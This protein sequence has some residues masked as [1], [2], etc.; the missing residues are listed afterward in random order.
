MKVTIEIP[1]DEIKDRL[2]DVIAQQYYRDYST[3]RRIVERVTAQCV[4]SIIYK[5]K[6]RIVDRIVSQA[7]RHTK[8]LAVKK[9]LAQM[10]DDDEV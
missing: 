3:D 10:G 4:R 5:D 1:E 8:N 9:M 7:S 2:L 6:E